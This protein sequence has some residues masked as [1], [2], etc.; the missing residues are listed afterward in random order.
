MALSAIVGYP[1]IGTRREL[2]RATEAYWDGKQTREELEQTARTLRL[3]AWTRMRDAGIG[4]IPSNTFSYYDQV[5]DTS[6]M[7]GAVPARYGWHGGPVD[8]DTYFAMARGSGN[9]DSVRPEP[10]EGHS[11]PSDVT[12]HGNDQVVRHQLPLP[13]PRAQCR[14]GLPAR[15]LQGVR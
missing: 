14:H 1:R 11:G 6:V 8:L 13:R 10:V 15:L 4:L 12:G 7:V 3:E 9:E 5:L 2:K